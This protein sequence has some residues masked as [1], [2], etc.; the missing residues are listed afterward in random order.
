MLRC[1]II[2]FSPGELRSLHS[3]EF[4][5]PSLGRLYLPDGTQLVRCVT[6]HADVVVALED[7]LNVSELEGGGLAELCKTAS[8][9]DNL[10]NKVICDLEKSLQEWCFCCQLQGRNFWV[11]RK[12]N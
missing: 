5:R 9:Y 1:S 4:L 12:V 3:A 8:S 7:K 2:G 10:I 11:G 6:R